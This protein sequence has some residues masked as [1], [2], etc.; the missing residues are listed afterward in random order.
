MC[1]VFPKT[2]FQFNTSE[3]NLQFETCIY[4]SNFLFTIKGREYQMSNGERSS[5]E[6]NVQLSARIK[7]LGSWLGG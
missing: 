7:F 6:K 2:N 1:C 5:T 3:T 4:S